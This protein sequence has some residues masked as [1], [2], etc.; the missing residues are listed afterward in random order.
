MAA[1]VIDKGRIVSL[2]DELIEGYEV[3]APVMS[4]DVVLFDRIASGGEARLDFANSKRLPKEAFFPPSEVMFVYA[5]GQPEAPS[6]TGDRLLFG[7]RPCDARSFLVL[8]KVFNT[9]D[10]QDA[11]YVEKR[12]RTCIVG[13]GCNRPLSTCFCTSVGGGPFDEEGLD[14]LLSDLGDRYLVQ[15]ISERGRRLLEGNALLEEA[16]EA[17]LQEKERIAT[18]ARERIASRVETEGLSDRLAGMYD[19]PFWETLHQKCLGCGVCTYLCPTCHCFDVLDEGGE[20]RG[21][22]VRIWD[23]C[24][25]P[26]FTLHASGHNPRPSGRERMRQR[27]MHKFRYF[28][29]N[30][31]E[32]A[33]VGCGRCVRNCPVNMD[34]REVLIGI[35]VR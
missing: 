24:Q 9:P 25:S 10:Y 23:T 13:I 7:P 15:I 32:I 34:L 5:G 30:C 22:R 28:V 26:L 33:C 14:V 1:R 3:F 35:M 21:R 19:D 18:E 11:Y 29:N 31:G 20:Q 6:S 4:D 17:D 16:T 2:L 12:E 27:I 8:G